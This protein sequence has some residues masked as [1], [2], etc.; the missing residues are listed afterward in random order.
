MAST[1]VHKRSRLVTA[2]LAAALVCAAW[3]LTAAPH[4]RAAASGGTPVSGS[5][6]A[7]P[8]PA[9]SVVRISSASCTPAARCSTNLRMVS[10]HGSLLLKGTGLKAGM[11]VVFP[12]TPGARIS[13]TSPGAHLHQ[14][15]SG[16]LVTVPS[17]AHSGRIMVLINALRHTGSYGPITIVK[18]SLHPP[19]PAHVTPSVASP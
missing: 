7:K 5:G 16:L 2:A 18:H 12:R 13:R 1:Y 19:A 10:V 17:S 14:T 8:A 15:R 6:A 11:T 9:T 4:A 3:A